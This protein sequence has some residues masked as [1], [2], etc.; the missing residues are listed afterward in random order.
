VC[1]GDI[2]NGLGVGFSE[3]FLSVVALLVLFFLLP[4][5]Y[6]YCS[7]RLQRE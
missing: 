4:S 7:K 6:I 5:F 3:L 2:M 1:F